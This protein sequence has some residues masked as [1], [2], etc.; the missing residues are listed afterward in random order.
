MRLVLFE[1]FIGFLY[2]IAPYIF[3]VPVFGDEDK[4]DQA[5][6][7]FTDWELLLY[8]WGDRYPIMGLS[9]DSLGFS[10]MFN[11]VYNLCVSVDV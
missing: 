11:S 5:F 6:R 9:G 10:G 2:D 4:K 1:F 8:E 3:W 7:A